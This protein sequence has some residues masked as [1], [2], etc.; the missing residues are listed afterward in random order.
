MK[1]SRSERVLRKV[2]LDGNALSQPW[3]GVPP[4]C[5]VGTVGAVS[6]FK[7]PGYLRGTRSHSWQEVLTENCYCHGQVP[8]WTACHR[9]K[10]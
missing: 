5:K 9:H 3:P 10:L 1:I 7:I 6:F 2:D 8:S 4:L